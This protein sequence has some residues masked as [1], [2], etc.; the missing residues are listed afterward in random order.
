MGE[1]EGYKMP[2]S[3]SVVEDGGIGKL[4]SDFG[5]MTDVCRELSQD[6]ESENHSSTSGSMEEEDPDMLGSTDTQHVGLLML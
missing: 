1:S 4:A 2:S 3:D 5:G 6:W